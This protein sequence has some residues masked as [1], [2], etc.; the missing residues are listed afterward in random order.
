MTREFKPDERLDI[1]MSTLQQAR[2]HAEVYLEVKPG[3]FIPDSNEE[4]LDRFIGEPRIE[5]GK[6]HDG[7]GIADP[8]P[9]VEFESVG[10]TVQFWMH[11][12]KVD[13]QPE[14]WSIPTL[15]TIKKVY[16]F[17]RDRPEKHEYW[18]QFK[19]IDICWSPI[20][21]ERSDEQKQKARDEYGEDF[22]GHVTLNTVGPCPTYEYYDA[23]YK[24][25]S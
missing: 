1:K 24:Y 15:F 12:P 19:L 5:S 14:D 3:E 11:H 6:Y 23:M 25:W 10:K 8:G 9:S 2:T 4:Y 13:F 17:G 22:T 16:E 18:H 21:D 7:F 20:Y